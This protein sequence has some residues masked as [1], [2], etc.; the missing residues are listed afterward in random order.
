MAEEEIK[1]SEKDQIAKQA[2]AEY[3]A[4]LKYRHDRE[5]AWQLI[6]DFAFNRVKKSLK[7]R[8]NVPVPIVPGFIDVWTAD[9]AKHA[10]LTFEPVEQAD[11]KACKKGTALYNAYKGKDDYDF[12]L[13]DSDGK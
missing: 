10:N 5:K 9:M 3:H 2:R 13:A 12:D 6:E 4:G 11:Y 7:S 1:P 8:F